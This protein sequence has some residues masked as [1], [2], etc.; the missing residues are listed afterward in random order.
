MNMFFFIT[1]EN[2]RRHQ[3][4]MSPERVYYKKIDTIYLNNDKTY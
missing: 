2:N 4:L 3:Q 1:F